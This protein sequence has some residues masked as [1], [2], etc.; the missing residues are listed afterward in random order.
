[1][2]LGRAGYGARVA[3]VCSRAGKR[4]G[5]SRVSRRGAEQGGSWAQQGRKEGGA[6]WGSG[7]RR[8]EQGA[9][10][11]SRVGRRKRVQQGEVGQSRAGR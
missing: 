7:A 9:A 6:A 11:C 5:S 2:Q 3:A 4:G 8:G 1:M 10:E